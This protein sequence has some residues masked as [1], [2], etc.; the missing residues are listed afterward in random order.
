VTTGLCGW[1]GLRRAPHAS[2]SI[3]RA[4]RYDPPPS[5]VSGPARGC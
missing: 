2:C 1:H 5:R 3:A 4:S